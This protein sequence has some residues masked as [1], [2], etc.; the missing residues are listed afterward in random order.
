MMAHASTA[1]AGREAQR[2]T[3]FKAN[4]V[5]TERGPGQPRLLGKSLAGSKEAKGSMMACE[6]I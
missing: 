3:E 5:Y 4:L 2:A 6:D 1:A